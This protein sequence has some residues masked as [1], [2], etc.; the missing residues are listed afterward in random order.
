MQE[1]KNKRK[2]AECLPL[3]QCVS[4]AA[5]PLSPHIQ[6]APLM[7]GELAWLRQVTCNNLLFHRPGLKSPGCIQQ[8]PGSRRW[9]SGAH[10]PLVTVLR[11]LPV[12]PWR[13]SSSRCKAAPGR[14]CM[15]TGR[16]GQRR[17]SPWGPPRAFLARCGAWRAAGMRCGSPQWTEEPAVK[18][19]VLNAL[20][21]S[22]FIHN[23][24]E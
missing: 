16:S 20:P 22:C 18:S 7:P 10:V 11:M 17:P 23:G 13:S 3:C 8:H 19:S 6:S 5:D 12:P 4:A 24:L 1:K 9:Q 14:G 2:N 21:E 15:P